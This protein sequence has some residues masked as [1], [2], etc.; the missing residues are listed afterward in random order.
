MKPTGAADGAWKNWFKNG[1]ANY[2][3][4]YHP[5]FMFAKCLKR[6]FERPYVMASAALAVGYAGGYL[7]GIQRVDDPELVRYVRQQQLNRLLL[8]PSLWNQVRGQ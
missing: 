4:G 5:L 8:R 3:T 1:R 2:I 7:K 6:I